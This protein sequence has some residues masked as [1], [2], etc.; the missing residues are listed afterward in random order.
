MFFVDT[1]ELEGLGNRS[2]LAGGRLTTVVMDP[3]RDID[4]LLAAAARQGV[5]I[6]HVAETH[7]H[8]DSVTGGLNWHGS[9]APPTLSRPPRLSPTRAP[10]SAMATPSTWRTP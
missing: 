7:V 2:Y 8:N 9:P 1:I 5:R 6:S 10:P 4:Q 3:P